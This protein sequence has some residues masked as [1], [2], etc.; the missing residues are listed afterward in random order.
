MR[1]DL[2][3]LSRSLA[4][5]RLVHGVSVHRINVHAVRTNTSALRTNA[6]AL[7]TND[8]VFRTDASANRMNTGPC[9]CQSAATHPVRGGRRALRVSRPDDAHE[10]PRVLREHPRDD[11]AKRGVRVCSRPKRA[12]GPPIH[13]NAPGLR[14]ACTMDRRPASNLS[15]RRDAVRSRDSVENVGRPTVAS[16][17][18]VLPLRHA[19]ECFRESH[20]SFGSP[21]LRCERP[22]F[23]SC[24]SQFHSPTVL[25]CAAADE[26]SRIL[27][28]FCVIVHELSLATRD[29]QRNASRECAAD[30]MFLTRS[31]DFI[32]KEPDIA[33]ARAHMF[34]RGATLRHKNSVA[35][36]GE[37]PERGDAPPGMLGFFQRARSPCPGAHRNHR[38]LGDVSGITTGLRAAPRRA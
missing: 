6:H 35:L 17:G 8:H 20:L 28:N 27:R 22:Q 23:G 3:A 32:I 25:F 13:S 4:G 15:P 11:S 21:H 19:P 38:D 26:F 36:A 5:S 14:I 18:R 1:T 33:G 29:F 7:H 31:R 16:D 37:R 9:R 30:A 12:R 24:P 10:E 34:S 2:A